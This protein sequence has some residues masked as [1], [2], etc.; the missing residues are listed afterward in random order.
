MVIAVTNRLFQWPPY[1][2]KDLKIIH[3]V[4][5]GKLKME[6]LKMKAKIAS[7]SKLIL[8]FYNNAAVEGIR[9]DEMGGTDE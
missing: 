9:S 7:D 6:S 2:L 4:M 3:G 8:I 1:R 5:E